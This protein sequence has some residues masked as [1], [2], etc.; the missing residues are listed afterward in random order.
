MKRTFNEL[1]PLARGAASVGTAA[2]LMLTGACAPAHS[3]PTNS[4]ETIPVFDGE[5]DPVVEEA[6]NPGAAQPE[7]DVP[8]D[9]AAA[10]HNISL[11]PIACKHLQAEYSRGERFIRITAVVSPMVEMPG[12]KV[13]INSS[14]TDY[15][16]LVYG[17]DVTIEGDTVS[18]ILDASEIGVNP[19]ALV[20][21]KF[22]GGSVECP[23]DGV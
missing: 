18:T 4:N 16:T 7:E 3:S 20:T 23:S 14:R 2:A 9:A 22:P 1:N 8:Y 15:D 21:V 12:L 6:R 5:P 11:Q 19:R 17:D 10:A 13:T